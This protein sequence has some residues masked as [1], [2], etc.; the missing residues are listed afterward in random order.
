MYLELRGSICNFINW[1]FRLITF[2]SCHLL[3]Q[4]P[5]LRTSRLYRRIRS[6]SV[7]AERRYLSRLEKVALRYYLILNLSLSSISLTTNQYH[8]PLM[9]TPLPAYLLRFNPRLAI[10]R[11]EVQ[12]PSSLSGIQQIGSVNGP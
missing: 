3:N 6:H 8:S 1:L 10:S 12:T 11:P 4:R 9:V 7:T 2:S 5:L